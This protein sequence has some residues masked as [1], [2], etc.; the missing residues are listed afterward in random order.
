MKKSLLTAFAIFITAAGFC[1]TT[2][3]NPR[4]DKKLLKNFQDIPV[5]TLTLN[6]QYVFTHWL[7][8]Q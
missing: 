7:S 6:K 5:I 3:T 8:I 4:T 2:L 1:Q